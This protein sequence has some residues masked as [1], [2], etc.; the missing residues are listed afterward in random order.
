MG[1]IV[2]I[3]GNFAFTNDSFMSLLDDISNFVSDIG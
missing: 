1:I 3:I 2:D